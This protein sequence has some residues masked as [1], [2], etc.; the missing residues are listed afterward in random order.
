MKE[1]LGIEAGIG[2]F[3]CSCRFRYLFV[4]LE[5]LVYRARHLSGELEP[6]EHDELRWVEPS[7][8][9]GFDFV[10]ADVAVVKKLLREKHR[11]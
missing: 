10:K 3:V 4:G 9:A 7:E 6:R 5:L 11:G 2:E 8:L 1:E